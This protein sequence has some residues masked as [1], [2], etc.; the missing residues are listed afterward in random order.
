MSRPS[1]VE[2][3]KECHDCH[4]PIPGPT[5]L[6]DPNGVRGVRPYTGTLYHIF[7]K[8]KLVPV[9]MAHIL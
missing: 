2:E 1:K 8:S 4:A 5:L 3:L 6:A 7:F 9:G